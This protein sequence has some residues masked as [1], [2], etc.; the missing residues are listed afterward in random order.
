[1]LIDAHAHLDRYEDELD[2]ALSQI[3]EDR[4]FT[5]STSMGLPSY[6]RNLEI[7]KRCRLVLPIFGIHPWNASGYA[8]SLG[9]LEEAVAESPMLGEIGL[10]YHYVRDSSRY[11]AQ[12]KVLE[13]FL[14]AARDRNK[15]VN[16]HTKGAERDVL[17]LLDRHGIERAIVHWYSGP[18]DTFR[19]LMARGFY[20]TVGVEVMHSDHIRAVAR[21]I[22]ADLL[23]TE[24]DNP[25]A[26]KWLVGTEGM[27]RA[28][29]DVIGALAEVRDTTPD[30]IIGLVQANLTCLIKGDPWVSSTW[31]DVV[32]D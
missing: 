28:L 1:M 25:G 15:I 17:D 11:T 7:G 3:E 22:P 13:F 27:P 18:L 29:K 10:D 4:I 14:A 20:F 21:Q 16:L 9:D 26:V 12:R 8:D 31:P 6:R 30:E 5:V 32:S 2:E 23:L 24:T 19:E